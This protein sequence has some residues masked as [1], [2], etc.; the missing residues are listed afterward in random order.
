MRDFLAREVSDMPVSTGLM[1]AGLMIRTIFSAVVI[2][3]IA[4]LLWKIAKLAD[5]YTE[6]IKAK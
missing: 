5:A 4:L 2:A 1:F 3:F 6:K